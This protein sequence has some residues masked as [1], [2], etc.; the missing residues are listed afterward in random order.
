MMASEE[1]QTEDI[2][3]FLNKLFSLMARGSGWRTKEEESLVRTN[4]KDVSK[5]VKGWQ[6]I[7]K[8]VKNIVMKT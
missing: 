1:L 7:V 6:K 5:G 2:D 3:Y 4:F 8:G